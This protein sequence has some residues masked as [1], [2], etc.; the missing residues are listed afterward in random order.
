M[1]RQ[2]GYNPAK[3]SDA[4]FERR[5]IRLTWVLLTCVLLLACRLFYLQI[6]KHDFYVDQQERNRSNLFI[7]E[8]RRGTIYDR[9]GVVLARDIAVYRLSVERD[10]VAHLPETLQQLSK[11]V[12]I[13]PKD[14]QIFL[15]DVK[16]HPRF[17]PIPLINRLSDEQIAKFMLNQYRF[18]G[19]SVQTG[20]L[21]Y[22]PFGA[23]HAP[24]L[25]Y[26]SRI[27]PKELQQVDPGN[28]SA[29]T[30]IGKVGIEKY[31][32]TALHGQVGAE[33]VQMDSVGHKN[34]ALNSTP[35]IA[36]NNL[37]LT[38]D[39]R[40][41]QVAYDAFNGERGALVAIQP[42][43]G[44]VLALVSSPSYDPNLFVGGIDYNTYQT[45]HDDPAQPLYNRAVRGTFPFGSTIKP[46]YA[47]Q[48]L[49]SKTITP[50]FTIYDPGFFTLPGVKHVY[51]NW[52]WGTKHGG[53]GTVNI[54]TALEQSN[55]TFF[56]TMAMKMGIAKMAEVLHT[57][58]F[59][60][61]TDIEIPEESTG[62]I[63]TPEWK[64]E[65]KHEAWYAGDTLAAGIGQGY[66]TTTILQ[67][68][69]GFS[70]IATRGNHLQLTLLLQT[71]F[72]DGKIIL[73][74]NQTLPPIQFAVAH[75]D[76]VLDGLRRVIAVGTGSYHFGQAELGK[77]VYEAAGKTGTAQVAGLNGKKYNKNVDYKLRDNSLLEVFAPMDHPEIAVAVVVEHNGTA[78]LVARKVVDYYLLHILEK[79]KQPT[80]ETEVV[81]KQSTEEP[82]EQPEDQDDNE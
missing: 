12:G 13:T 35:A 54:T 79:A 15:K 68:A 57:F 48:G 39:S 34:Q 69:Q 44:Q 2:L 31:F 32:E 63:G 76:V 53:Q 7:L 27:N 45:L 42:S 5:V 49:E 20:Y 52:T 14:I 23:S 61:K 59:G 36:G 80:K 81:Q 11:L 37:T 21:R 10:K 73:H 41:Q 22:Y 38:I 18:P 71:Q 51:H 72:P 3:N 25:G 47:L 17:A 56:F 1:T 65:K 67:L 78:G 46:F 58:G 55:D 43:T 9:N 6:I 29:S 26:I 16:N 60:K 4:Q 77:P 74:Q 82:S 33:R 50:N 64:R 66:M 24:V 75:W 40:L 19:V 70:M 8:P 30:N 28:Y 62:Y